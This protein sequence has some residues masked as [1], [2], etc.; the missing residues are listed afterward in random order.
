MGMPCQV[1]SIL[2]LQRSQGYPDAVEPGRR[3]QVTKAGYRILPM[4]VPLQLVDE[5]WVAYADVVVH[6]LTWEGDVTTIDFEIVRIY[7]L[8]FPLK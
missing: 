1:N 3:Y 2:R 8:P 5:T 6:R 7:E 4:D